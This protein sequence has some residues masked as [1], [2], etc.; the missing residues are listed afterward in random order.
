MPEHKLLQYNTDNM[1]LGPVYFDQV[2]ANCDTVVLQRLPKKQIEKLQMSFKNVYYTAQNVATADSPELYLAIAT[3]I[4]ATNV[5]T[6]SLP[7]KHKVIA[8]QDIYRSF[9]ALSVQLSNDLNLVSVLTCGDTDDGKAI[10]RQDNCND[11]EYVLKQCDYKTHLICG[12]FH[13]SPGIFSHEQ[14]LKKYNYNHSFL[15]NYN[16]YFKNGRGQNLD[17]C[18]CNS[19]HV[20]I[21]DIVV[22][23]VSDKSHKGHCAISYTLTNPEL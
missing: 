8:E 17:R 23:T 4:D 11:I 15:D 2:T 16:T 21:T 1:R 14:L 7:S 10:T 22:N 6:Y 3:S 5:Q 20:I 12:D 13:E 19:S 18:I 9:K